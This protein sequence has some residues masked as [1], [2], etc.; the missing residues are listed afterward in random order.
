MKLRRPIAV[1]GNV[2]IV[3]LT[4]GK[5]ALI[6][7]KDVALVDGR[8]WHVQRRSDLLWYAVFRSGRHTLYMHRLIMQPPN[9]LETDHINH[10][11]LD[12]RRINLRACTQSQNQANGR[13]MMT[14]SSQFRGVCLDK[15]RS[16]WQA[17]IKKDGKTVYLGRFDSEIEAARAYDKAALKMYGE[18][19]SPNFP[20]ARRK[21]NANDQR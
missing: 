7:S 17:R 21:G 15:R 19:A 11:G 9:S 13:R 3:P 14:R 10:D 12:N 6:D 5:H 8:N 1:V 20:R 16:E 4:R 18:F 2:A